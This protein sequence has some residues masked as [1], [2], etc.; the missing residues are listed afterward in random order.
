MPRSSWMASAG[1][2]K[3]RNA[4]RP[5]VTRPR[6]ARPLGARPCM[7]P[8]LKGGVR[9]EAPILLDRRPRDLVIAVRG[10]GEAVEAERRQRRR[11]ANTEKAVADRLADP[12]GQADSRDPGLGH[13]GKG[14]DRA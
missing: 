6:M 10:R 5:L 12:R 13:G 1:A 7:R 11:I 3:R 4:S 9:E 14:G 2:R 8:A